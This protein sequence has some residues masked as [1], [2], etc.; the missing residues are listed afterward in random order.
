MRRAL[1]LLAISCLGACTYQAHLPS[2]DGSGLGGVGTKQP[3]AYA[4]LVQTGG[5][6]MTTEVLGMSCWAHTYTAD[7][8][9]PWDQAMKGAF[10][11]AL[12]KVEFVSTAIAPPALVGGGYGAQIGVIQSNASSKMQIVPK[13]F[14][15]DAISETKLEG[16]LTIAYPDGTLQQEPIKGQGTASGG[17]FFCGDVGPAIERSSALAIRDIVERTATTTKLL[18]AQHK[19]K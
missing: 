7:L 14:S 10:T 13:F 19:P 18:L 8:N 15:A 11:A 16:I 12:D 6:D 17:V 4:A 2:I 9:G 3:G 5:W 1:A